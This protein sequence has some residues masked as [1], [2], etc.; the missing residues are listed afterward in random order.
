MRTLYHFTH[1]PFSRRTRLALAHKGLACE[2]REA[3]EA[4][5]REQ[6]GRLV[7]LKTIPV[8]VDRDVALADSSAIT[9]WLDA[10]YP[11]TARI[12]P[13]GEGT[14]AALEVTTLVDTALDNI[15][16]VGTRYYPLREHPSFP[17]V[18]AEMLG[19]A[20]RA[21]DTLGARAEAKL[22]ATL[23][24]G[25]WSAADMWLYTACVWL[26]G[27][28]QRVQ[29]SPNAA[30]I[31]AL[32]GWTLPETVRRWADTHHARRDVQALD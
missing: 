7:A 13:D 24:P 14:L 15:V 2:L 6:A 21:L 17:G 9:R 10:T 27:L 11:D 12:W 32:G 26:A 25:G 22:G 16:N 18:K 31:V 28:P 20:Q 19:R 29:S 4:Q 1:S 30:Q 23:A 8:L 3:R 5:W